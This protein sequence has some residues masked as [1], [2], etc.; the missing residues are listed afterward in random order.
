M[1]CFN[2]T[3][4]NSKNIFIANLKIDKNCHFLENIPKHTEEIEN[5]K[6]CLII[7]D[8]IPQTIIYC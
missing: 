2:I 7:K 3:R 6:R 5:L 1:I 4:E 8:V